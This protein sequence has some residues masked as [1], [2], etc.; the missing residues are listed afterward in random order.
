M[1]PADSRLGAVPLFSYSP[2]R[3][4]RKKQAARKLAA[5]APKARVWA[6]VLPRRVQTRAFA[7]CAA[8]FRA[9][10]FFRSALDGL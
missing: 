6:C 7:A 4:E 8:N 3:A 10:C 1:G 9:A 5:R 2:S